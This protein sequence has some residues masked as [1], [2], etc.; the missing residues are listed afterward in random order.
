ME[1]GAWANLIFGSV[2]RWRASLDGLSPTPQERLLTGLSNRTGK[3][4]NGEFDPG[5]G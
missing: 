2:G 1:E 3:V 5:S 4:Y